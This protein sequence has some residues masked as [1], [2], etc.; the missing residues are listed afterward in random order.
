MTSDVHLFLERV[1]A[2]GN[3]RKA[4]AG[5]FRKEF[6]N[7]GIIRRRTVFG[8]NDVFN[9]LRR[10]R[11]ARTGFT[12][13]LIQ[14]IVQDAVFVA[15]F[16]IEHR[17]FVLRAL[18]CYK[19]FG[20][21]T[22]DTCNGHCRRV[23]TRRA[24]NPRVGVRRLIRTEHAA[25]VRRIIVR[26]SRHQGNTC[27]LNAVIYP[28]QVFAFVVA[29]VGQGKA[30]RRTQAHIDDV[31]AK[32]HAIFKSR[33]NIFAD[34]AAKIFG[35]QIVGEHLTDD[36]LTF[37]RN[38]NKGNRV[39][40]FVLFDFAVFVRIAVRA[41]ADDTRNV[42]TVVGIRG[43]NVVIVVC[44]VVCKRNFIAD[45]NVFRG[46]IAARKRRSF[47]RS[48]PFFREDF[49]HRRKGQAELV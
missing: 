27:V 33:Q 21:L 16:V 40:A 18:V 2:T 42:R 3:K 32:G 44:I 9:R 23:G 11:A 4:F 22:A 34:C 6:F 35:I 13:H 1:I 25:I 19:V 8:N 36:K 45:V 41:A 30:A 26:S 5:F 46:K 12:K 49:R 17:S 15:G 47:F 39:A 29:V 7:R 38:A 24:D 43:I 20:L 31:N 37:R 48:Q 14:E 10:N 28:A